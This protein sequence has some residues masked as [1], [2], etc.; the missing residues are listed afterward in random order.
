MITDIN[1]LDPNKR[2]SYAD[3]LTWKFDE[4]V[5]LIKGKLFQMSPAPSRDHQEISTRLLGYFAPIVFTSPCS[6][7]HAPFDV[8]ILPSDDD[9]ENYSVVQPDIC[10]VCDPTK[11]DGKGCVGAPDLIIEI[12]S[13]STSKRDIRD[14]FNLYEEAGVPE[15]WIVFPGVKM[16]EVFKLD[17]GKYKLEHQ[18]LVD[19]HI[20]VSMFPTLKIELDKVFNY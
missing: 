16:I 19:D 6:V 14:K 3:Y 2:Y 18:Y 11:L 5:E 10:V 8:R 13:P 15:Y 12:L 9:S 7:F 20:Q 17:E 1:L 4:Y